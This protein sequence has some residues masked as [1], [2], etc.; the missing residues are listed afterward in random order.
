MKRFTCWVALLV[1]LVSGCAQTRFH[2][3]SECPLTTEVVARKPASSEPQPEQRDGSAEP[4]L[5]VHADGPKPSSSG[6]QPTSA[7]AT[8]EP[9]SLPPAPAAQIEG[10]GNGLS[11]LDSFEQLA[12][13]LNPTLSELQARVDAANGRWLQIGLYPN[14]EIAYSAPEIGNGGTPGQQGAYVQQEFVT[15][16]K[17]QLNRNAASWEVKRVE[18]ELSAQRLRVLTDIRAGFYSLRVAQERVTIA[19]ELHGIAQQAVEK[20]KELVKVQ[21]PETVLTQAEIEAELALLLLENSRVQQAAQWRSL[22]SVVGQP[23]LPQQDVTGELDVAAPQLVWE[24]TLD[25]IRR[26]S[27]EL[28]AVA[29]EV[30]QTRWAVQRASVQAVPNV[31]VQAGSMYDFGT[32]DP[33]A[34]LQIQLPVPIFNRNQGGIAEAHAHAIAAERA[35]ERVELSLQQRL[36]AV[37][38][39][40]EQARQQASRYDA[41]ILKKARRNLDLNRQS[42]EAGE[43]AYLGVLTA[44]R[45]Y[46]QA[47]LAWLNALEQLWSATVQIEGLLLKDSLQQ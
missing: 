7:Q 42:Y 17:L 1:A 40:Y 25:R 15:A 35:V 20:A 2:S 46:F 44:Q 6:W 4:A 33:I 13:S 9:K 23:D 8:A 34:T 36:A 47:K 45:S 29:A 12:M 11:T 41:T 43:S 18:Q 21:E 22:M 28:A 26:E 10:S 3:P 14:P 16:D 19:E 24:E 32:R 31:T 37:Y 27:P 30:E 5:I 38:Q 39:Q